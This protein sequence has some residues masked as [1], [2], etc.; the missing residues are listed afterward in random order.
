M[1]TIS[2]I[3][4]VLVILGMLVAFIP[5]LGWM[6][7]GV[8]PIAVI[9]LLISAIT[10]SSVRERRGPAVA[11]IVLCSVAILGGGIRLLIGG[12]FF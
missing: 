3:I 7:W 9:G 12:G 5:F 1:R 2:L 8:I 6:N 11:G 4:G 10:A